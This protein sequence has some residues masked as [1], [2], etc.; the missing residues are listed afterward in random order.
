SYF[1]ELK[2]QEIWT[3][4]VALL[5]QLDPYVNKYVSQR[6]IQREVLKF[7]DDEMATIREEFDDAA[8]AQDDDGD[9][10]LDGN[11]SFGGQNNKSPFGKDAIDPTDPDELD[12]AIDAEVGSDSKTDDDLIG[13]DLSDGD[14]DD[15]N[16]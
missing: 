9:G 14:D 1:E 10:V 13:A 16:E 7:T 15:S 5:Q 2:N 4:R 6:W 12:T 8:E 3:S 11:V